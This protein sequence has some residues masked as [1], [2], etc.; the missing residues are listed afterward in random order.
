MLSKKLSCLHKVKSDSPKKDWETIFN[1]DDYLIEH[2]IKEK[3]HSYCSL[4]GKKQ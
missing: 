1:K 2:N 4:Q 3:N